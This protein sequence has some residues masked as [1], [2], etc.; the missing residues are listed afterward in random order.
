MKTSGIQVT[1]RI[2]LLYTLFGGIWVAVS[3]RILEALVSDPHILSE[4]QTYKGWTF[5]IASALL[6]SF[7]VR[8]ELLVRGGVERELKASEEKYRTLIETANDAIFVFDAETGLVLDANKK[9]EELFGLPVKE[10]IGRHHAD[11]HPKEDSE[12]C[13]KVFAEAL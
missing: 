12:Q 13:G 8:R 2:V 5:V 7:M 10:I 11:L 4:L 3:D 1:L 6:L 9:A